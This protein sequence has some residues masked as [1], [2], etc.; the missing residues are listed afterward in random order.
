MRTLHNQIPTA[1]LTEQEYETALVHLSGQIG[2]Q[3]VG[4]CPGGEA[5]EVA[6][7]ALADTYQRRADQTV[8][9]WI[10]AAC[11]TVGA[12]PEDCIGL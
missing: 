2:A 8:L 5:Y 6:G 1:E 10:R 9:D 12:Y 3:L 7:H 11:A 4:W